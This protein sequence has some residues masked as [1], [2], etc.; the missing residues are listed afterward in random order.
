[1]NQDKNR[2]INELNFR[3]QKLNLLMHDLDLSKQ[4]IIAA[5]V[6]P[7]D[8]N[9]KT[10]DGYKDLGHAYGDELANKFT[11]IVEEIINK[12]EN[13]IKAIQE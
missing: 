6:V 9:A 3:K 7:Y 4:G 5:R 1:M 10:F 11:E 8:Y 2:L 13:E 12:I